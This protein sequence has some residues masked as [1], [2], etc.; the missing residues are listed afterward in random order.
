M[1][2]VY[3][4]F[5]RQP[6]IV[7]GVVAVGLGLLGWSIY[8]SMKRREEEKEATQA[9][10]QAKKELEVLKSQGAGPTYSE[11]QFLNWADRLVQAMTG[12]G[13]DED[14]ILSI[15]QS[16]RNEADVRQLIVSFGLRYYQPCAWTSPVAYSIWLVNDQ[17][18]GGELSTWLSSDLSDNDIANIN[19]ILHS[20]GIGYQF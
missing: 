17:A 10:L 5:D 9:A 13:T 6:P 3:R 4:E 14:Q 12:C 19:A 15:F 20:K 16:M 18:Y 8:R 7:K 11:S 2:S 1:A